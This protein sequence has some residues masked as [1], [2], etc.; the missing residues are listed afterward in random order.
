M[1]TQSP[2]GMLFLFP[3]IYSLTHEEAGAAEQDRVSNPA[4]MMDNF[5]M[6]R[7]VVALIGGVYAAIWFL[8]GQ[9]SSI[10]NLA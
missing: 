6:L 5:F 3:L 10:S 7:V 4:T 1:M 9:I 2:P 8:P